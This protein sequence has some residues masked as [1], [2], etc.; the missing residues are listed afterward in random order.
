[1]IVSWANILASEGKLNIDDVIK[2]FMAV[3]ACSREEFEQH[4]KSAF[5]EWNERNRYGDW[6]R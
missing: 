4:K 6:S 1:M 2:H 5:A 3:N